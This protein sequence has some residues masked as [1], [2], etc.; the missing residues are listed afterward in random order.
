MNIKKRIKNRTSDYICVKC[1]SRF[2]T[3]D[4]KKDNNRISTFHV[5]ECG[6]C[7]KNTGVTHIRHFNYLR[8]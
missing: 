6:L 1:G 5:S 7:G 2:L 4:Q 8:T 3:P